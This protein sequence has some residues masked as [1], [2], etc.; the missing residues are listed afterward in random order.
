MSRVSEYPNVGRFLS[1]RAKE[2]PSQIF[3][4]FK[5]AK[6][7]LEDL[8]E[9]SNSVANFLRRLGIERGKKAAIISHTN[10]EYLISEFGIFKS[11]AVCVPMNSL[12]KAH[13]ISYLIEN[14]GVEYAFVH[15]D[16]EE[17]FLKATKDRNI[18]YRSSA[19]FLAYS[20]LSR[21]AS[22]PGSPSFTSLSF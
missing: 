3:A 19:F 14:S 1:Q 11:G 6:I 9:K 21:E 16:C 18:K 7:T 15:R 10:I 17:E 8:D 22:W 20:F 4:Y 5:D 2:D 13:E 12:L